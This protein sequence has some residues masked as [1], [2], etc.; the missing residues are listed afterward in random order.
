M[1]FSKVIAFAASIVSVI[2]AEAE[3]QAEQQVT[4]KFEVDYTIVG[5]PGVTGQDVAE[6]KNG[7]EFIIEYTFSNNE[8]TDA[9]V[10]AVGGAI[11]DP[12]ANAIAANLTTS[13]IGPVSVIPGESQTFRQKINVDMVPNKYVLAPFIYL[14]FEGKMSAL[15]VR[16]QLVDVDDVPISFFN[17]QLLI[18]EAA[19]ISTFGAILYFVY[20]VWGKKYIQ[21]TAPVSRAK[22]AAS[23]SATSTAVLDESWIPETHLKQKKS[24]KAY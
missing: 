10:T 18:L 3:Q 20:D 8:E 12:V 16:G 2:A 1:K 19:L 14:S 6:I 9:I 24:K 13:A 21:G 7:E 5:L 23:P 17:P 4:S 22:K 15:Q 11:I